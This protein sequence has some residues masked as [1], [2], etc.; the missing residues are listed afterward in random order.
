MSGGVDSA[1]A[2]AEAIIRAVRQSRFWPPGDGPSFDDGFSGICYDRVS[3]R[4]AT[5]ANATD[6][7]AS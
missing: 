3:D 6:G 1:V 2:A 7:G 4:S 5:W